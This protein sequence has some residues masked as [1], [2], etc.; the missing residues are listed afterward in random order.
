[1]IDKKDKKF[2][3]VLDQGKELLG[4]YRNNPC[5]ALYDLLGIDLAPIQRLLFNDMWFKNYVIGICSR[6]L[7]KSVSC[8]SLVYFEDEGLVYLN[9]KLPSVPLYLLDGEDTVVDYN[10]SLYTSKGFRDTQKLCLEKNIKGKKLVTENGFTHKGGNQHP[11]LTVDNKNNFIYK[12]A[13]TFKVRDTVCILSGQKIFN[14]NVI[15]SQD[16]YLIGLLT[17]D[18]MVTDKQ[19]NTSIIVND[20][21]IIDFC[22]E[23]CVKN[24]I[25]Y[26]FYYNKKIVST[27]GF[28][29]EDFNWF[30]E[31]YKIEKYELK[32]I[33]SSIRSS[34]QKSQINFFK[35]YYGIGNVLK[36]KNSIICCSESKQLA[37]E[38][39]LMLLNFG[40]IVKINVEDDLYLMEILSKSIEVFNREILGE[41]I[42]TPI[43]MGTVDGVVISDD[44]LDT[45]ENYCF[46]TT[47]NGHLFD[48]TIGNTIGDTTKE[49]YFDT[50]KSVED[51][52]GDCYDFMMDM[53]E[54]PNYFA[55][56]FINHNTF[57]LGALAVLSSLLYPGYRT[58]LIGSVFRQSFVVSNTYD[59]FWTNGGL[60]STGTEFYNSVKEGQ[61]KIQSL[62]TQNTILSKWTNPERACRYIKTKKGFELAG[63][64]DHGILTL[65]G[66]LNLV[67]KDLQD[68]T[69]ED[70]IVIKKGFN[71]FGNNNTLPTY[72][73]F[74]GNWRTKDCEI[75]TELT[76]NLS[77]W[78]GLIIGDGCVTI[79]KNDNGRHQNIDF[80]NEDQDLLD[81]FENYLREYFLANKDEYISRK[82]RKNNTWEIKYPCKKLVGYLLK[83]GFTKTTALDKK[84]PCVVKK[85]SKECIV[86]FISALFDT[87][88]CCYIQRSRKSTHCEVSLATS[89]LQLAKEVQAVLLNLG[90]VSHLGVSKKAEERYLIGRTVKSKCAEAYKIRITSQEYLTKFNNIVGFRCSRKNTKLTDYLNTHFNKEYSLAR[91]IGLPH[92]TIKKNHGKCKEFLERGLYFVK[93]TDSKYFFAET[94]D[95]EVENE[96]CY[97]S[98]G[99]ISHNS[100]MIFSEVEKIY[101]QSPLVREATQKKPIRSTDSCYL[102]FK[103]VGGY[104]G[105]FIEALP[106]GA[107]GGKIR[108]SRFYTICIDELAQ[109]PAK[110]VD[111]VIR[112][113]AAATLD[114]MENVRQKEQEDKLLKLGLA[115]KEDFEDKKVNKM[116]MVSS[117]FYKFN[118]IWKRMQD[119]WYMMSKEGDNSRYSVWQIPYTELPAGFLDMSNIEESKRIMATDEFK[120]EYEA[121][122]ISDSEGFFKASLIESC[123]INSGFTVELIGTPKASY[124]LGVDPNQAG[125]AGCG[126]VIA[127]L[128]E[129]NRVVKCID[130]EVDTTQKIAMCVQTICSQFNIVRVLI[131]KGG[132]G[133]AVCDLLEE[134]YNNKEPI[135]DITNTDHIS[136]KGRHILEMVVFAPAWISDA[137][138]TA[139]ALLESNSISFP[140]PPMG[141]S[142]DEP[143]VVYEAIEKLKAQMRNIIVTQTRSGVLHFDTPKKHQN[144][145]LYS[146]LI[147]VAY[148]IRS[149]LKEQEADLAPVL[150]N[151][152]GLVRSMD[153]GASWQPTLSAP[154]GMVSEMAVLTKKLK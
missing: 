6:G 136:M 124:I 45:T 86:A 66:G 33:P 8:D 92:G 79:S 102:K 146:A 101:D 15:D 121:E 98:N 109:V 20:S 80:V 137:N 128:G 5:I 31:K 55:N 10:E 9:E 139:K 34:S 26:K 11:L 149:V 37:I 71:Y 114:P 111:M 38:I 42:D 49:Y 13:D 40:V 118:H 62:D 68:I 61:T 117:G 108:G 59:T 3:I 133:K 138:F 144:K 67:F 151:S 30:I 70:N 95:V 58:G 122:M 21:K 93:M 130:L 46:D 36:N 12:A 77:Y 22:K 94:V 105:S 43:D 29:F 87:D 85:S 72:D 147:L 63:T 28:V 104:N 65:D 56:G 14:S 129:I 1:M 69:E 50:I 127:R 64:V 134:G 142:R 19:G 78:I 153:P 32:C 17:N 81:F 123:S 103:A 150:H 90:I 4:F 41:V 145:D 131:D 39:Q 115:S 7:G 74:E 100:K 135:I 25:T 113:F 83:C 106:L 119:H 99:M 143:A 84:I 152:S 18:S 60:K 73:E 23:Y 76:P 125:S 57:L 107:D 44:V 35:G 89:S 75:P 52:T 148:G 91:A 110:I 27:F 126:V 2:E 140:E 88:G 16:A 112:P 132:G 24:N 154:V 47:E 53:G 97:W 51:W 120:M 96:N 48:T 82:N 54:E 141:S 116:I